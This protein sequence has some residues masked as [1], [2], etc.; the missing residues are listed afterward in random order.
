M[1]SV[2]R[3]SFVGGRM[4]IHHQGGGW[5]QGTGDRKDEFTTKTRS[6]PVP[7]VVRE[8]PGRKYGK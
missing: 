4:L 5:G 1:R 8:K 2:N 6:G 3:L 7:A